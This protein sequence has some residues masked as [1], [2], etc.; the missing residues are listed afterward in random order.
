MRLPELR[1]SSQRVNGVWSLL[2][3]AVVGVIGKAIGWSYA[4]ARRSDL[5]FVSRR[6]LAEHSF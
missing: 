6:W 1:G 2:A 4:R 5:G 3:L